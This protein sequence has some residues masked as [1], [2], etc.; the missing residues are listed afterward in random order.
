M[1]QN[2]SQSTLL[3]QPMALSNCQYAF[4]TQPQWDQSN[5]LIQGYLPACIPY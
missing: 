1:I 2:Q 4:M 5:T 3:Y